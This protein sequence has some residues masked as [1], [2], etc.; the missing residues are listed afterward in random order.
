MVAL[1]GIIN[2][3]PD[4]FW[5]SSRVEDPAS[6]DAAIGEMVRSGASVIDL[7]AVSTRPGASPV[8]EEDEWE[9]L[10]RALAAIRCSV[11]LSIDTTRSS[12][13]RR[14]HGL[15]A[16]N[17]GTAFASTLIV[18]DISA[19]E[20]DDE[21]LGTVAE[22]GLTY[23]AM[24]KRG[25]PQ[26]MDSLT[27][28]EPDVV[29]AVADYFCEFGDRAAKAGVKDWILDPGFGF[30]KTE[31]QNLMLLHRLDEFGRF[32]RP[33]LAGISNKRFTR[34][35]TE[36]L[37]LEAARRGASILRVHDV[38]ACAGTLAGAGIRISK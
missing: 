2:L 18:N 1:M 16:R 10:E 27:S 9:R 14:V 35:S 20:E 11:R 29:A 31:E 15:L 12:I 34:G 33:V 37:Q 5:A 4:S 36:A 25:T 28:Y 30:A 32:G 17:C 3:T 8:S 19:G 38:G 21:M 13:I 23:I 7:G 6:L 24:H 22:L 26:T